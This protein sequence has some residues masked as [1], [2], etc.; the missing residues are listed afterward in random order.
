MPQLFS[1]RAFA[2][3][4]TL[5]LSGLTLRSQGA[6][7]FKRRGEARLRMSLAA[8]S[9]RDFFKDASHNRPKAPPADK[10][11]DLFQFIDYCAE[12][13]CQAAEL[14]SYYFPKELSNDFLLKIKR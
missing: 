7:P 1:R 8:Y 10:Q 3:S 12:H 14:T 6:E 9:F 5:G 11:I 13:D 2:F 4:A